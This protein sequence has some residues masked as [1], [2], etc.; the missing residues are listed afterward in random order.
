MAS[1]RDFLKRAAAVG[2]AGMAGASLPAVAAA[3]DKPDEAL[4]GVSRGLLEVV[5]HRF[6][7]HE[8]AGDMKTIEEEIAGNLDAAAA[9]MRI[10][11]TNADEPDFVFVPE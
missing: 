4:A 3:G 11:I 2:A 8:L 6:A 5:R 10:P 9:M 1:R 7:A